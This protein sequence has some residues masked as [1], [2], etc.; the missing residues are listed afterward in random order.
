MKRNLT[1]DEIV[2]ILDFI[3]ENQYIPSKIAEQICENNKNRLIKQLTNIQIYPELIDELKEEIKNYYKKSLIHAGESVGVLCAQSIG[4]K[5]TQGMLNT[6]HKAGMSEKTMTSGVPRFQ[7]LINA[8]KKPKIVNNKIYIKNG[9]NKSLEETKEIIGSN[10]ACL[11]LKDIVTSFEISENSDREPWYDIFDIIY[12]TK[13][14][15]HKHCVK[16]K[17]NLEKLFNFK[18]TL[19][20]ISN[21]IEKEYPDVFCVFSPLGTGELHIY[22]D[23]SSIKL[24]DGPTSFITE[25]NKELMYIEECVIPVLENICVAGIEGISEIFYVK[26]KNNWIVETN[27]I[28][29]RNISLAFINYKKIL[30][31]PFIDFSKTLSN[32]VWDILDVLGIEAARNALIDEFMNIMEGINVCH[33]VLLVER[34][35]FAGSISSI[36]RYTMKKDENGPFGKASFEETMDNFLNAAAK[37]EIE[38]T[39]SVSASIVCGKRACIGTGLSNLKINLDL[40][41]NI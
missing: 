9:E 8:T 40:L 23:V 25:K 29:S 7:E 19:K 28:N 14:K 3:K 34:M 10:I 33:A 13:Y 38:P 30:A 16:F 24:P 27:G 11:Y 17:L 6:F 12:N 18:L 39:E 26:E 35:T 31:L 5:Q 41:E 4:E 36:T 1:E 37:G 32:N 22:P 20:K 2:Y 21:N 15:N